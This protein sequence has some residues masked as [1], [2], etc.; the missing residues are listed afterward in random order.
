MSRFRLDIRISLYKKLNEATAFPFSLVLF[1]ETSVYTS[2][3]LDN[4]Y[5]FMKCSYICPEISFKF[6]IIASRSTGYIFA[7]FT[8]NYQEPNVD[9]S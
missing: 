4:L 7:F 2:T 1:P 6:I 3:I 5:C 8:K 9:F